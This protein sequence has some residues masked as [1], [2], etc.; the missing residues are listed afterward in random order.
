MCSHV[1]A[2]SWQYCRCLAK[3]LSP[4]PSMLQLLSQATAPCRS[5]LLEPVQSQRLQRSS[6]V[7]TRRFNLFLSC[8]SSCFLHLRWHAYISAM[9]VHLE[10]AH[11]QQILKRL[12]VP[13]VAQTLTSPTEK[14]LKTKQVFM[15]ETGAP[16][17]LD[18]GTALS[19][20]SLWDR[21]RRQHVAEEERA[22]LCVTQ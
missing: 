4:S 13:G 14:R 19:V 5:S 7:P 1:L 8:R 18:L 21:G 15:A 17:K 9:S 10:P 3:E 22:H 6:D 11:E 20:W 2:R 16:R 12:M